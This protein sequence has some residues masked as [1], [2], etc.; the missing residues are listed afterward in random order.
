MPSSVWY[1]SA[2]AMSLSVTDCDVLTLIAERFVGKGS[3][4]PNGVES[5]P[6]ALITGMMV[7]SCSAY[8]ASFSASVMLGLF[9]TAVMEYADAPRQRPNQNAGLPL[10]SFVVTTSFFCVNTSGSSRPSR[11]RRFTSRMPSRRSV[12]P[13]DGT[14]RPASS[15]CRAMA[16][17]LPT[18]RVP[19]PGA[20]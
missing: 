7:A 19:A 16:C 13:H 8:H 2:H 20:P 1:Q 12:E 6:A 10:A 3:T 5:W 14:T 17:R 18:L 15:R 9:S 4:T 11:H